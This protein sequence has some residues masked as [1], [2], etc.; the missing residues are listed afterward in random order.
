EP[1]TQEI[2]QVVEQ[3]NY[4]LVSVGEIPRATRSLGHHASQIIPMTRV[5]REDVR[6]FIRAQPDDTC[7]GLIAGSEEFMSRLFAAVRRLHP[8]NVRPLSTTIE[9]SFGLEW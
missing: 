7:F 4:F 8:L 5:L 1:R 6:A 3:T 9:D 2:C